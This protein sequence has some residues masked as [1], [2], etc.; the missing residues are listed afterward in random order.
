M[1]MLPRLVHL[2]C[3]VLLA[4]VSLAPAQDPG[5]LNPT[6]LPPLANPDSP[7]TPAKE[8]FV[9]KTMPLRGAARSIGSYNNGCLAGAAELP[10]TG[11]GWQVMRVS[12]NRN[13]GS[14]SLVAFIERLADSAKKVGWN[15]VLVACPSRAEVP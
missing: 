5:T 2:V 12:R 15:G 8:L 9:R 11:P 7:K 4:G 3:I 14:P 1:C 6:P 10:I 13:W